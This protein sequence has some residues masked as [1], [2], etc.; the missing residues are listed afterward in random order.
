MS[1]TQETQTQVQTQTVVKI[2]KHITDVAVYNLKPRIYNTL[3][4]FVESSNKEEY[5]WNKG[6]RLGDKVYFVKEGKWVLEINL[7]PKNGEVATLYSWDHKIVAK[8]FVEYGYCVIDIDGHKAMGNITKYA[9]AYTANVPYARLIFLGELV[10][11]FKEYF[12]F[13]CKW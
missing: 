11:K 9:V 7:E 2:M 13:P 10:N 5:P 3:R 12:E 1:Q 6:S 4:S 8:V